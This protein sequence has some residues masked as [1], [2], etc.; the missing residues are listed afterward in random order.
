MRLLKNHAL[1]RGLGIAVIAPLAL[2]GSLVTA[3]AQAN[4]G[5][6]GTPGC[7]AGAGTVTVT[8]AGPVNE[9]SEITV[10]GTGFAAGEG[11][12]WQTV[13]VK[14]DAAGPG[15][16][17]YK[18]SA[19]TSG[20]DIV[21][22]F[23]LQSGGTFTGKL[24]VP[25]DIN[26]PAVNPSHAGPHYLRVLGSE[27]VVSCWSNDFTTVDVP[28]AQPQ[29][30]PQPDQNAAVNKKIDKVKAQLKKAKKAKQAAK[31]KKLKKRLKKLRQ[32]LV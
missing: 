13:S 29:P 18:G 3:P 22:T 7:S 6:N 14:I 11:G 28:V 30:Q 5:G 9:G 25:H 1:T 32:Q 10:T 27:P 20:V 21:A 12:A 17:V 16:G 4:P 2:T 26:D 23:P 8:P 24:V 31:V 15:G 19:V